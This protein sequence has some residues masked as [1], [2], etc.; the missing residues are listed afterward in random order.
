MIPQPIV[1]KNWTKLGAL[2]SVK[3]QGSNLSY[4]WMFAVTGIV[5]SGHKIA[6]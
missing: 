1:H 5:E 4:S 2:T 6:T 3:N